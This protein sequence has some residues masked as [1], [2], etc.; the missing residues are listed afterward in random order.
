MRVW[1]WLVCNVFS[2]QWKDMSPNTSMVRKATLEFFPP[3]IL[4]HLAGDE[5]M[6]CLWSLST[7]SV[8][9]VSIPWKALQTGSPLRRTLHWQK[10]SFFS[11]S[12]KSSTE[13]VHT[14]RAN[15]TFHI[16]HKEEFGSFLDLLYH[17]IREC[18]PTPLR[19]HSRYQPLI[20]S[21][22]VLSYT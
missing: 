17:Q 16:H 20:F 22:L 8:N 1:K 10:N 7:G 5:P 12:G 11:I 13:L 21:Q 6:T 3:R 19:I 14:I 4:L 9:G 15:V 18:T 2:T